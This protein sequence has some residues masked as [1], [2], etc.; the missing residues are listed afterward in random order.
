MIGGEGCAFNVGRLKPLDPA[1]AAM[2]AALDR[3]DPGTLAGNPAFGETLA[4][5]IVVNLPVRRP[6]VATLAMLAL[7]AAVLLVR[8]AAS[9]FADGATPFG[10]GRPDATMSGPPGGFGA[11]LIAE[12]SRFYKG[13]SAAIRTS[14]ANGTVAWALIG[15][16]LA[17]GVFH[18]AGPGPWQ[19]D[20][21]P[22]TSSRAARR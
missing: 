14:K 13:L 8:G 3:S 20:H 1:Q 5:H 19:G 4:N 6:A 17:Y 12:Q 7:A 9:A 2:A 11:W 16:S 22:P 18:A 10:V 21:T 15:L